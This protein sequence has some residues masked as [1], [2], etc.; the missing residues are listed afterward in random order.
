MHPRTLPL[1]LLPHSFRSSNPE[2]LRPDLFP[3]VLLLHTQ[4]RYQLLKQNPLLFGIFFRY[5][6]R[7]QFTQPISG[8]TRPSRRGR[9]CDS[10]IH[11]FPVCRTRNGFTSAAEDLSCHIGAC[12]VNSVTAAQPCW[13]ILFPDLSLALW[14]HGWL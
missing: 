10:R 12:K 3:D 7:A 11:P 4:Q 9:A 6:F 2:N 5:D 1:S 8:Q 13:D 14:F